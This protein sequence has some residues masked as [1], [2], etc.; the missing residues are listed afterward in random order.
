VTACA[1]APGPL[2]SRAVD[3]SP[4]LVYGPIASRRLGRS[5]GINLSPPGLRCCSFD[6][7]YCQC[8]GRRARRRNQSDPSFP[9]LERVARELAD[10]LTADPD[11]D[12]VCFAGAGEPTLHPRFAEVVVL[13]C[14]LRD[15]WAPEA[16]VSVLSNGLAAGKPS[17][18]GALALVD[19][20]VVKL[21]AAVDD[22][23]H[24]LDGAPAGLSAQRLIDVYRTMSGI[25]TQ[26]LLVRGRVDNATPEALEALGAALRVIRPRRAQV[27]TLTRAPAPIG[28]PAALSPLSR[29]ELQRAV[30]RLRAAAP[31][32]EI[33]VY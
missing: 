30:E 1:T 4:A 32:V 17:V 18:R 33:V 12:D 16:S 10:A 14:E 26:T 8:G 28:P 21:D 7:L 13:A 3:A 11:V 9:S 29:D 25:E 15:R 31:G 6:C 27:G 24:A 5:L 20:A 2:L 19:H 23:L 22:L